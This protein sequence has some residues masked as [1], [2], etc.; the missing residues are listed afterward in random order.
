[1]LR[2]L[3]I[4]SL[5]AACASHARGPAWPKPSQKT[6]DGGESL[7]PRQISPL[8]K[9]DVPSEDI[10]VIEPVVTKPTLRPDGTPDTPVRPVTP[11]T[12]TVTSPDVIINLDDVVID[13]DD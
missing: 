4:G 11:T 13:V 10:T 12:P 7:A 6:A 8:A 3:L 2:A 9:D 1:M 5:L